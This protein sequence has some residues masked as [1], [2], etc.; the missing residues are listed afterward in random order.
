[1]RRVAKC[2]MEIVG[3]CS[4]PLMLSC[5]P[6]SNRAHGKPVAPPPTP[7]LSHSDPEAWRNK[8]P[9]AGAPGQVDMPQPQVLIAREND[10]GCARENVSGRD[11]G[12]AKVIQGELRGS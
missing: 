11:H 10:T 5:G 3:F 8:E 4:I 6:S 2:I 9:V 7:M 12:S 1:M